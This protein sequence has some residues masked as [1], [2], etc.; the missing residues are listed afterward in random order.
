MIIQI[1]QRQNIN[2]NEGLDSTNDKDIITEDEIDSYEYNITEDEKTIL[3][4]AGITNS[5]LDSMS[6]K[7]DEDLVIQTNQNYIKYVIDLIYD[8][9]NDGISK[10]HKLNTICQLYN[11]SYKD[12]YYLYELFIQSIE[13]NP[14]INPYEN[15]KNICNYITKPELLNIQSKNLNLENIEKNT[16]FLINSYLNNTTGESF[17][18][19]INTLYYKQI[20]NIPLDTKL[21]YINKRWDLN[22]DQLTVLI[23]CVICEAARFSYIDAYAVTT[24]LMNRMSSYKWTNG[25]KDIYEQLTKRFG[26][27][28]RGDY[29]C[30]D[31]LDLDDLLDKYVGA[32]AVIDCLFSELPIHNATNFWSNGYENKNR[33]KFTT[34]G[35]NYFNENNQL[36]FEDRIPAEEL[37]QVIFDKQIILSFKENSKIYPNLFE[38]YLMQ[39]YN[40]TTDTLKRVK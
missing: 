26:V 31:D 17:N 39:D 18:I 8:A 23:K 36:S 4:E 16:E 34:K 12:L 20:N 29:K 5:S 14:T 15:V 10:E 11:C 40:E 27:Y 2:Q 22:E 9:N 35:N 19:L 3:E 37:Q 30:Y 38:S 21:D 24:T 33:V 28:Y 1:Y 7:Y 13:N 32:S 6:D 25:Y